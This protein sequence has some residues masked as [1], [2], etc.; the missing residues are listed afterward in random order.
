MACR[1][2]YLDI[3][4]GEA[5][6]FAQEEASY[7]HTSD[8]LAKYATSYTLP[9]KPEELSDWQ[10]EILQNI[11]VHESKAELRFEPPD[12]LLAG[13]L[14][15]ELSASPKLAKTIANFIALCTGE[16]GTCKNARNKQLHYLGCP[17]HRIAKGFVA[18][19]GDIVRGDGSGGESIYGGDF[20]VEEEGLRATPR[21]GSLGMASSKTGSNAKNTSQFFVVLTDDEN[22]LKKLK[23]Q[24]VIFGE[25]KKDQT[26]GLGLLDR[27]S[28]VGGA[29]EKPLMPVWIGGCGTC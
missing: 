10:K 14:V 25:L 8:L 27:L 2:V 4:I 16:K 5:E 12:P 19:G 18:Q 9:S 15:F 23:G 3:Y 1:Q 21:K 17:I 20:K 13:R 26:E 6:R 29:N 28:E 24:Y 11:D 22:Q 7:K